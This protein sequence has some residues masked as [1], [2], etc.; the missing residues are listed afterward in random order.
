[1]A[2]NVGGPFKTLGFEDNIQRF[3]SPYQQG[4]TDIAKR[5]AIRTSN[6]AGKGIAD[7][8]TAQGG[9]G[10]YREAIQQGERER[11]LGQRLDDIQMTGGQRA[12][13]AAVSALASE[14][15]SGLGAAQFGLQQFQAGEG[16]Q[17]TQEQLM[18]AAFQAGEQARQQAASLGLTA[19][20][21]TEASRQA[22]EK[23]SQSG[24][25]L[26]QQALQA[27]GAQGLDAYKAQ[28]AA[29]QAQGAQSLQAYQAGEQAKQQAAK[30]GLTAQQQEEAARQAQEKFSQSAYDMSNRFNLAS[31][32]GLMGAGRDINQDA[33]SRIQAL[34]GIGS[35]QRAL[36]QAGLDIG[37]EDFMRQRDFAQS[38]L[39]L[40]GNLLRGV[41]VQPQQ[42][43]STF[44]QQPG[45]FQT[46]VGAGL[47]GLGLYRGMG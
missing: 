8:A 36:Q 22:Q 35:Q 40:F 20:Q 3:M 24:F 4:V 16:A 12:Y 43:V 18:Q 7:A 11:N 5:E 25:Q 30:L 28:Q 17:Q 31:A 26:N 38:Q 45:L 6:I 14:R 42:R 32:Q 41:P 27:Q 9:L 29:M 15:A 46:A 34:Q 23:F 21:Q 2:G 44:Q 1:M 10:G 39:G 33:I 19:E 47:G 37:Y 13:D